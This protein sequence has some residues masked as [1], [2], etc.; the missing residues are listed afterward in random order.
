[1]EENNVGKF[2]LF[3]IAIIGLMGCAIL[4]NT[5]VFKETI[6]FAICGTAISTFLLLFWHLIKS[7]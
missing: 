4:F 1:M 6:G 2:I 3:I 5:I 7:E